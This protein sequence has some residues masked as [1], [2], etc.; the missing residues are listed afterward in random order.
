MLLRHAADAAQR[1]EK[2]A[3]TYDTRP[4]YPSACV[5]HLVSIGIL[6]PGTSIAD[7]GAGTGIFTRLLLSKGARVWAVEPNA[8]M[9]IQA[10][11][12]LQEFVTESSLTIID[13]RDDASTLVEHSLDVVTVAE[14]A[15]W[16]SPVDFRK[17]CR[18]ILKPQGTLVLIWN[19]RDPDVWHWRELNDIFNKFLVSATRLVPVDPVARTIFGT[20]AYQHFE[21]SNS[22]RPMNRDAFFA[23]VWANSF[24]PKPEHEEYLPF[25]KEISDFFARRHDPSSGNIQLTYRTRMF[26]MK[27]AEASLPDGSESAAQLP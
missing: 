23:W 27:L 24:V 13:G 3:A 16:F 8:A 18:R 2:A 21:A 9:R 19:D 7:I 1:F 26:W 15:H 17:E 14:A 11:I 25:Q 12:Q 10:E 22:N 5:D 20:D 4:S 6:L